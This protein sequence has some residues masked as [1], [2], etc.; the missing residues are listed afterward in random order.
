[1][2]AADFE[3]LC[4]PLLPGLRRSAIHNDAN[5][6]NVIVGGGR[7]L[8]TRNQSVVGLV[9]FGD[10]VNSYTVADLAVAIAY[11]V[12]DQPEPLASAAH[13]VRGYHAEYP[14][15]EN[16]IAALFGLVCIRL[17]MS[18]CMAAHQQQQRPQD[19]YLSISQQPIRKTLPRLLQIH[20]RFAEATF[21]NACGW[22]P[23][24][25]SGTVTRW[26]AKNT[27]A[28]ASVLD[29]NIRTEP[30]IVLDLSISS[31]LLNSDLLKNT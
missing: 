13:V 25:T 17:C 8:Y 27:Q 24:P 10:M 18:I 12:L 11:A 31:P 16:E 4:V 30:C 6:Y 7:D 21:R 9:D 5:D 15:Q 14:L 23:A 1:K 3:R 20:P 22:P 19:D 26:L 29:A 2:V 28:F